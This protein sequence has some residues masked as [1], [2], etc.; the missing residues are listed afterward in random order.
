LSVYNIL[1]QRIITLKNE[2]GQAGYNY[3]LWEGLDQN[4]DIVANGIYFL[5]IEVK[6]GNGRRIVTRKMI[7]TR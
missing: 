4:G 2:N 7:F 1:G 5:R 3:A 6:A